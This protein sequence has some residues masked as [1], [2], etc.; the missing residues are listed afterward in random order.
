MSLSGQT[1]K[2]YHA[3]SLSLRQGCVSALG[4]L[5]LEGKKL[6]KL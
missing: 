2:L 4:K 6:N 5:Y 3:V 1:D